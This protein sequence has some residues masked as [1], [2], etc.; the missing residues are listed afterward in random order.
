MICDRC[1]DRYKLVFD[2]PPHECDPDDRARFVRLTRRWLLGMV[3]AHGIAVA[4][5][6]RFWATGFAWDEAQRVTLR[7]FEQ[8]SGWQEHGLDPVVVACG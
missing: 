4:S 7:A 5:G 6:A 1:G 8:R 3:A 2:G